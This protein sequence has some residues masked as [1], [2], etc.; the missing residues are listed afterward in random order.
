MEVEG[1]ALWLFLKEW[2]D[3]VAANIITAVNDCWR[4]QMQPYIIV[5]EF[6]FVICGLQI[7]I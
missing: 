2:E 6:D 4:C 5:F 7:L 3:K 1:G